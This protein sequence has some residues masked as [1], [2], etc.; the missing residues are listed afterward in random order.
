MTPVEVEVP[1]DA[2]T[3][4][5]TAHS[6]LTCSTRAPQHGSK[7]VIIYS[8][9]SCEIS[10]QESWVPRWNYLALSRS[11]AAN[12]DGIPRT[13]TT[14]GA[15]IQAILFARYGGTNHRKAGTTSLTRTRTQVYCAML[16]MPIVK[17]SHASHI[18]TSGQEPPGQPAVQ[19]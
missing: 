1:A 19:G 11:C 8:I 18:A 14:Q 9:S 3:K 15:L 10:G 7:T 12:N 13:S 5:D 16:S 4:P 17:A 2:R 6:P